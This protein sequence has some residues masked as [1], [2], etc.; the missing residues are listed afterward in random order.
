MGWVSL[1]GGNDDGPRS[2][3]CDLFLGLG[4]LV[5]GVRMKRCALIPSEDA[6]GKQ[7]EALKTAEAEDGCI[8]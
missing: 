5:V 3:S 2:L 6:H 8:G 7:Q 4:R 1:W